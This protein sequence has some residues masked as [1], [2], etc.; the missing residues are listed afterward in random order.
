[1]Q[2]RANFLLLFKISTGLILETLLLQVIQQLVFVM[3]LMLVRLP[4]LT[5]RCQLKISPLVS[6]KFLPPKSPLPAAIWL[7]EHCLPPPSHSP[8]ALGL[9]LNISLR[10]AQ[11]PVPLLTKNRKPANRSFLARGGDGRTL[12]ASFESNNRLMNKYRNPA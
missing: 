5:A 7:T 6:L 9:R 4:S 1:M 11:C 12:W 10:L 8:A 2:D 3:Q